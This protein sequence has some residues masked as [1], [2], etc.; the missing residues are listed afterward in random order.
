LT[1]KSQ[2]LFEELRRRDVLLHHPFDSFGAVVSFIEA[3][4]EDPN[5]LSINQTLYRT[6]ENSAIV[7]A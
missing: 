1:A 2:D 7:R 4:A 3:A 6:S 5:V